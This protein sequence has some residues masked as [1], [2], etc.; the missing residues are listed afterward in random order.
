MQG[1]PIQRFGQKTVRMDMG[2]KI[3]STS[4]F[5]VTDSR[6][7]ILAAGPIVDKGIRVVLN[8]ECSYMLNKATGG[9][10]A[11]RR[12]GSSWMVEVRVKTPKWNDA[13][14]GKWDRPQAQDVL[15]PIFSAADADA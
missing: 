11:L 14:K 1:Q 2:D 3:P 8:D 13:S 10:K 15:A 7:E 12:Q 4:T 9:I 6:K 5:E